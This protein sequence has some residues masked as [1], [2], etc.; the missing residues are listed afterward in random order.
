VIICTRKKKNVSGI[1]CIT[2]SERDEK[3]GM[4]R[5]VNKLCEG[6]RGNMLR[7]NVYMCTEKKKNVSGIQ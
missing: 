6:N 7:E 5:N 1:Q 2:Y 4:K 3:D